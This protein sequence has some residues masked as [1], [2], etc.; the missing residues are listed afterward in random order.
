MKKYFLILIST[1]F[2]LSCQ[3][4][5][6]PCDIVYKL[7]EPGGF[8]RNE[9]TFLINDSIVW[10]SSKFAG[11]AGTGIGG[12]SSGGFSGLGIFQKTLKDEDDKTIND[13][14]NNPIYID[15]FALRLETRNSNNCEDY[16]FKNFELELSFIGFNEKSSKINKVRVGIANYFIN[17]NK[18]GYSNSKVE[19]FK[20]NV[21]WNKKDSIIHGTFSGEIYD[22]REIN[23]VLID[24]TIKISNGVF[25][26]R[27]KSHN[28]HGE[29]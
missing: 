29:K 12:F 16:Y 5:K 21:Y 11:G 19:T 28:F 9:V 7:N 17:N 8:G 1:V 14:L 6:D 27:Y 15:T 23:G 13:S 25:D 26:Y 20:A 18:P 24:D 2:L 4:E 10:H 22:K 3:S